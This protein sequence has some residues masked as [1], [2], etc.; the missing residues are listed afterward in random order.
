MQKP[1]FINISSPP[2]LTILSACRIGGIVRTDLLLSA[3]LLLPIQANAESMSADL[4]LVSTITGQ[5]NSNGINISTS[6]SMMP[7]SNITVSGSEGLTGSSSVTLKLHIRPTMRRESDP[8][9]RTEFARGSRDRNEQHR[10]D[11]LFGRFL[12]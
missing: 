12:G 8:I 9:G 10:V 7:G 11:E 6:I 1:F 3:L 2:A 4:I 5:A